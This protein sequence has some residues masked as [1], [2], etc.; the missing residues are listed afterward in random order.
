MKFCDDCDI[1]ICDF[2]KYYD[3]NGNNGCYMGEGYCNF[4]KQK[5]DPNEQ[6]EDFHCFRA[7][8]DK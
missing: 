8:D 5:R 4:H 2:C 7:K 1:A 3:F 6:C